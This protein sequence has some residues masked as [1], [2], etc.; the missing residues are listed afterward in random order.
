MKLESQLDHLI[1]REPMASYDS[2]PPA[3]PRTPE[4]ERRSPFRLS[5][6]GT[7]ASR[8]AH[9]RDHTTLGTSK[10]R[11]PSEAGGWK[12]W[13]SVAA[14]RE[15]REPV[16]RVLF[17]EESRSHGFV[18]LKQLIGLRRGSSRGSETQLVAGPLLEDWSAPTDTTSSGPM[19]PPVPA[20]SPEEDLVSPRRAY[21]KRQGVWE[22][23]HWALGDLN[24]RPP[25]PTT[26]EVAEAAKQKQ[27]SK[28]R[29]L[30]R[31]ARASAAAARS[32][33]TG[34]GIRT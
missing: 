1:A 2:T 27:L 7:A 12:H 17:E 26:E 30:R 5:A 15:P 16:G 19:A 10:S 32:A 29:I 4:T 31:A 9:L 22:T 21:G 33:A 13:P 18:T 28:S 25:E 14:F 24:L 3:R 8:L 20:L 11:R 34:L 23:G 6:L